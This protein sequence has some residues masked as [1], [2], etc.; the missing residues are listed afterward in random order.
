MRPCLPPHLLLQ[1]PTILSRNL[2]GRWSETEKAETPITIYSQVK[3]KENSTSMTTLPTVTEIP[4]KRNLVEMIAVSNRGCVS[5]SSVTT[6][7]MWEKCCTPCQKTVTGPQQ[8]LWSKFPNRTF[9]DGTK[10]TLTLCKGSLWWSGMFLWQAGMAEHGLCQ[11]LPEQKP[12]ISSVEVQF[13]LSW[14]WTCRN[15]KHRLSCPILNLLWPW[16]HAGNVWHM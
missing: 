15:N 11:T 7:I 12:Y 10:K 5:S 8:P 4:V 16:S 13:I 1:I 6:N 14:H 2:Q 9:A 3:E